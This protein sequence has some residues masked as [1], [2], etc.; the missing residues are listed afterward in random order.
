MYPRLTPVATPRNIAT[1][2][3]CCATRLSILF[4]TLHAPSSPPSLPVSS[5]R[6]DHHFNQNPTKSMADDGSGKLR[7]AVDRRW[8]LMTAAAAASWG[9]VVDQRRCAVS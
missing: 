5:Q 9:L 8:C 7:L 4:Y 3:P 6:I 1:A 2:L